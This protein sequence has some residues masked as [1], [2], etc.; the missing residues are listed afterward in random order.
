MFEKFSLPIWVRVSGDTSAAVDFT[1]R[2]YIPSPAAITR[3][4]EAVQCKQT[5]DTWGQPDDSAWGQ[6][7]DSAWGRSED[8]TQSVL[9]W[10][11]SVLGW[12][13]NSGAQPVSDVPEAHADSLFPVSQPHSRQKQGEDFKAFFA[14]RRQENQRKEEMETPAQWQS[15][16]SRERAAMNHSIPGKS[17]TVV[18]FEW[19][20]NDDFGGF[21]QRIRL[22]KAEIPM[23]WMSYSKSTRV[24]D[25]FHNEWDLCD[26]LD[27]TSIPDGDWEEDDF[28]PAPAPAPSEP[29]PAPPAPPPPLSSFLK[30]IEAYF[31]H[32]EVAPSTQYTRSVERF[33][34]ILHFHLGFH[35]AASTTTPRG[36]S[37]TFDDWARKTQWTH[38]CRLVGDNP[39]DIMSIPDTQKDVITCFIGYLVTLPQTQLS[40]IPPDLWDLGPDSS[41]SVSNAHIRV[42]FV[43]QPNQRLYIIESLS[44]NLV[45]WKLAV[46]DA[47]TAVMCLRR[48]WGSDITKIACNLMEKGIAIKTLQP[49]SVPPHARRPLTELHTYSLGHVFPPEDRR[50]A[51]LRPVFAD[52]IVYEQHRHEFLNQPRARAALLHGGLIWRLALHSLG[53]D[54]LPSVLDGISREAVPFGLMLDINGQT[55]F[56]DEL[57]E[58]E[59]DFMCGTYYL[60]TSEFLSFTST[61]EALMFE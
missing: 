16:Q 39:T 28:P 61:T 5:P 50:L 34:S 46:P 36:R 44:S 58:E 35:L 29:T 19:Q 33:V 26:A 32:Y 7:D 18:V 41:L 13:Q 60:H 14:R 6:P 52:Y 38:L 42:S 4:T 21:R 30:D 17:S 3:A 20:P 49:I 25:S 51:H 24:Y 8:N 54:V 43:Q 9:N 2:H 37:T 10:D 45:P 15:R 57:S 27:L 59:I 11:D 22:T 55:Y 53:F 1:L 12:G 23:T 56:D 47:I 48:D 31:G 40:D